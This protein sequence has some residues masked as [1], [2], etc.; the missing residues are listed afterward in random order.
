MLRIFSFVVALAVCSGLEATNIFMVVVDDFGWA[1]AGWHTNNTEVHTPNMNNFVKEGVELDRM[2][3]Y[4][5]CSPTRSS[6]QSGRLPVHVTQYCNYESV[7]KAGIPLGM[8]VVSERLQAAGYTTH[9]IGKW[10]VGSAYN[11]SM[12]MNRGFNSSL[13]YFEAAQDHY[14]QQGGG[15]ALPPW[16]RKNKTCH[17]PY[18]DFWRNDGPAK[19][20]VGQYSGISFTNEAMSIVSAHAQAEAKTPFY[21]YLAYQNC[22]APLEVPQKY[23]DRHSNIPDQSRMKYTAMV[24]FVDESLGNITSLMKS[25]NLWESTIM[26][27]V[28]DNGGPIG[29]ANNFPLKAGKV[30]DWDGG[31]RVNAFVS[32]GALPPSVRGTKREDFMHVADLFATICSFVGIQCDTDEKAKSAGLPPMDSIDMS[33]V[34][35]NGEKGNRTEMLLATP[36]LIWGN[37]VT[38]PDK[39]RASEWSYQYNS[40]GA[41]IMNNYKLLVGIVQNDVWT[42]MY[43]PNTSVPP[44]DGNG[45]MEV[46][47]NCTTGCLFDIIKDPYEYEDL[48][49]RPEYK[50]QLQTILARYNT[51][52]EGVY[53]PDRGEPDVAACAAYNNYGGFVGPFLN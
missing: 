52:A 38:A 6:I 19:D 39:P 15:L 30:S 44:K 9:M 50:Q 20:L 47:R 18:T 14:T 29:S 24:D 8:T 25:Q 17:F 37:T 4:K 31:M 12:P 51:L 40:A 35:L 45:W 3:A 41:L 33:K 22:H 21:I 13:L 46:H 16:F 27:L 5:Y 42:S 7:P 49:L 1:N 23:I 32:G 48:A 43:T 36:S 11:G 28:S 34:I 26:I 10:D 53:D 2:Y